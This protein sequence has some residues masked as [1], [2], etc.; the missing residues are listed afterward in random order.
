VPSVTKILPAE[1]VYFLLQND[2]VVPWLVLWFS[3]RADASSGRCYD[4]GSVKKRAENS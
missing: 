3:T 1:T 4:S 2:A